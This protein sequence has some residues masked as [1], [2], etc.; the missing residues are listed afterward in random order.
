[1][2]KSYVGRIANGID[3]VYLPR[4]NEKIKNQNFLRKI[5]HPGE[6]KNPNPS[7]LAGIFAAKEAVM[8]SL[9]LPAGRWLDIEIKYRDFKPHVKLSNEINQKIKDISISI[10]ND[11]DYVIATC[12]AIMNEGDQK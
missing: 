1:M 8:K 5:F 10:S 7:H 11:G 2:V 4:F 12:T 6:L 9:S 3:I